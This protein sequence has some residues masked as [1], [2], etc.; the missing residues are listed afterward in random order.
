MKEFDYN[1]TLYNNIP[2]NNTIKNLEENKIKYLY[3]SKKNNII[4]YFKNNLIKMNIKYFPYKPP[5]N[6]MINNKII[7]YLNLP[8]KIKYILFIFF[9]INNLFDESIFNEK[10]WV[11]ANNFLIIFYQY[12]YNLKLIKYAVNYSELRKNKLFKNFPNELEFK[13]MDYLKPTES[14]FFNYLIENNIFY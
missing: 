3:I 5:K 13:I 6:I 11:L 8:K 1:N 12:E 9:N 7:D 2:I 10:N 4:F 14:C